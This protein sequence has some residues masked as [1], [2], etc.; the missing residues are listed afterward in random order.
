MIWHSTKEIPIFH[1]TMRT[2]F[3]SFSHEIA[4]TPLVTPNAY[5]SIN[6]TILPAVTLLI[7]VAI[8]CL[9]FLN[10]DIFIFPLEASI[11]SSNPCFYYLL[12]I[13]QQYEK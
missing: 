6:E 8:Y 9:P 12:Q 13:S 11:A 10:K 1:A 3:S 5:S 7:S 4:I 2:D